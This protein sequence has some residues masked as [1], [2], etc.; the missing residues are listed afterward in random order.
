MP[1]SDYIPLERNQTL[2]RDG[3]KRLRRKGLGHAAHLIGIPIVYNK[4]LFKQAGLDPNKPPTTW[5]QFLAACAKLK[6]KGITPFAMGNKDGFAG[7]WF[8]STFGRGS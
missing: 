6:A 1:L 4:A 2:G 8:W 3:R 7:A 5:A